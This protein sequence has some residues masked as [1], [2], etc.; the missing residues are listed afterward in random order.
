MESPTLQHDVQRTI[1][2]Y[3]QIIGHAASRTRTMIEQLGAVEALS[4]LV[5]SSD[6]QPGFKALRDR[7]RLNESFEAVVTRHPDAFRPDV[8][9]AAQ[10]R[11]N[12][13]DKPR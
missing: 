9:E 8:V 3:E 4:R 2:V 6:L 12:T 5:V 1:D 10:W 13:A 11:L 7:G